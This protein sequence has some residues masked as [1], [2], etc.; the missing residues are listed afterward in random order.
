[1]NK[2]QNS[3]SDWWRVFH[4]PEMADLFLVRTNEQDLQATLAFLTEQ[5]DLRAGSHVYDQC[6]GIGS[7]SI[8]LAQ[9]GY[10]VTGADLCGTFIERAQRDAAAAGVEC[11]F[12]CRDAFEFVPAAPCDAAFNW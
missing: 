10:R 7:L 4:V 8:A 12:H 1:M 9:R 2:D 6:C 5:L 3:G 11:E